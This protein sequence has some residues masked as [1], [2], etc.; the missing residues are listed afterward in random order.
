MNEGE[1]FLVVLKLIVTLVVILCL[2]YLSIR[3]GLSKIY[4]PS[5][6]T[7][8]MKII[9]QL[10]LGPKILLILV[11]VGEEYFLLA[12]SNGQISGMKNLA[13]KPE[14]LELNA[15]ADEK[16]NQPYIYPRLLGNA[17][18]KRFFTKKE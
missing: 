3:F 5:G 7:N 13:G 4:T 14:T 12:S 2:A 15:S 8:Y 17:L 11:Q 18:L 9:E 6:R 16:E 10:Y 1:F